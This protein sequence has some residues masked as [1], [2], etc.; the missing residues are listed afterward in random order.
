[1]LHLPVIFDSFL[2]HISAGFGT[3]SKTWLSKSSQVVN[4]KSSQLLKDFPSVFLLVSYPW[5]RWVRGKAHLWSWHRGCTWAA[6]S[7]W[8]S[9]SWGTGPRCRGTGCGA[10]CAGR[11]PWRTRRRS[12]TAPCPPARRTSPS[13]CAPG[14][15]RQ[16][17]ESKRVVNN[18]VQESTVRA[19]KGGQQQSVHRRVVPWGWGL[20]GLGGLGA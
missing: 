20:G 7:R 8:W 1:M 2:C 5:Q 4:W 11:G 12:Q 19:Q 14:L 3:H 10:C 15:K 13:R 18:K 6:A 17:S 9:P 16:Q